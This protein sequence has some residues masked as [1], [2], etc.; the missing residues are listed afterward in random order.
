MKIGCLILILLAGLVAVEATG[1]ETPVAVPVE[2]KPFGAELTAVDA[3][4]KLTFGAGDTRRVLPAAGLVRWGKCPEIGHGPLLVLADGSLLA[5]DPLGS[6]KR[7]LKAESLLLGPIELPLELVTAAVFHAPADRRRRDLFLDQLTTATGSTDRLLLVNGDELTGSVS[8]LETDKVHLETEVGPVE[9]QTARVAA[10]LFN[11]ALAR[12]PRQDGLAAWVGLSDGSR[13][14]ATRL[15]VDAKSA[16]VSVGKDRSWTVAPGDLV[17]LQPI[18]GQAVYL[19]DLLLAGPATQESPPTAT[20]GSH[21]LRRKTQKP[22]EYRYVPY[23]D[24]EWPWR[25]DRNATGGMLRAGGVLFL[26]GLGVHSASRL[27]CVLE[28]PC[29]RFEASL[30]IDDSTDG[31]GSVR[32]FVYVDQRQKYASPVVRGGSEPLPVSVDL[33]GGSRVDLIVDYADRADVLDHANWLNARLI[34]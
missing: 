34:R 25:A 33:T 22:A 10:I 4:W 16:H 3:R 30:A 15:I 23:L 31:G 27:S 6:D 26:K 18:G 12:R 28:K 32:F 14:R 19:S 7:N 8:R 20:R 1:A 21:T 24:L 2:G 13:I 9:I 11:P 29:R 17:F 5:A